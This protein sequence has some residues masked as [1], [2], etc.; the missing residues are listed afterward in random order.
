[1]VMVEKNKTIDRMTIEKL[2]TDACYEVETLG[3]TN[4]RCPQYNEIIQV[5]LLGNSARTNC[6][7]GLM[8]ESLRG[9]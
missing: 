5:E 8:K 1:M 2:I 9:I 3:K 7:C 6:S 4:V